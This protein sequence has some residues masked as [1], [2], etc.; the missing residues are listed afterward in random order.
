MS[1]WWCPPKMMSHCFFLFF[2]LF[3]FDFKVAVVS[4]CCCFLRPCWLLFYIYYRLG[5]LPF[6]WGCLF[7]SYIVFMG[8]VVFQL[9]SGWC[10]S[11]NFVILKD[12]CRFIDSVAEVVVFI[13]YSCLTN[14]SSFRNVFVSP[15][16]KY[17][18]AYALLSPPLLTHPI[19]VS[20]SLF[21][22]SMSNLHYNPINDNNL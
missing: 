1:F 7:Q 18:Q 3:C 17:S 20:F 19:S 15:L 4:L 14:L 10:H 6:W 22:L 11:P 8:I 9:F 13:V 16:W 21:N 2:F 5:K 12:I